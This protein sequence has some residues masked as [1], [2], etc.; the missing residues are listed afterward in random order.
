MNP[1]VLIRLQP[2]LD[3]GK[4][5]LCHLNDREEKIDE[6]PADE[7]LE[8]EKYVQGKIEEALA[9]QHHNF[10]VDLTLIKWVSTR[11]MGMILSWYR[12]V[13]KRDG[14]LVL[15]NLNDRLKELLEVTRLDAVLKV[16][17]SLADAQ[18]HLVDDS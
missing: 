7:Q 16:F 9:A 15:A 8:L 10:I 4:A 1:T 3:P 18:R 5:T 6:G 12:F 2:P 17:D 13:S 14:Q 11:Y